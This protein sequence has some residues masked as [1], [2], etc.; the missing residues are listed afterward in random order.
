MITESAVSAVCS[1]ISGAS[2][3]G[4]EEDAK[5]FSEKYASGLSALFS[6]YPECTADE[7][8]SCIGD[9]GVSAFRLWECAVDF[10]EDPVPH[11]YSRRDSYRKLGVLLG[12]DSAVLEAIPKVLTF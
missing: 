11:V 1:A 8:V 9:Y 3:R 12:G 2:L 4:Y 6:A 7:V 5:A 10:A